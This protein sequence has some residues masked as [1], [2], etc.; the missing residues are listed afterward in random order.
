MRSPLKSLLIILLV[1]F[2]CT[3]EP[4][5]TSLPCNVNKKSFKDFN[6]INYRKGIWMDV[7][8][9][10]EQSSESDTIIF[11]SD[12][13]WS[14]YNRH[15]GIFQKKYLIV[16]NENGTNRN[17]IKNNYLFGGPDTNIPQAKYVRYEYYVDLIN[18]HVYIDFN[19]DTR[20]GGQPV[21]Y[22]KFIKIK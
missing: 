9:I 3:K 20:P 16:Q 5:C 7:T 17:Y 19:K 22:S 11:E 8:N 13:I 18:G 15:G 1:S 10:D 21:V 6:N 14:A 2:S 4:L 12:S